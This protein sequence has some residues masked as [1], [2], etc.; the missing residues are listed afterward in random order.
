MATHETGLHPV[1]MSIQKEPQRSCPL[2]GSAER[3]L[4]C[5]DLFDY[6][7]G[8]SVERW[9]AQECIE[10][11][12]LYL[13]PRPTRETV[14]YAY[15]GYYTHAAVAAVAAVEM[16]R[17]GRAI[18]FMMA[19]KNGVLN[20]RFG[21]AL[22]PTIDIPLVTKALSLL[23]RG[24]AL[25]R[26]RYFRRLAPGAKVLDVGC[27]SGK[28]LALAKR[29]GWCA[30]GLDFDRDAIS[31]ARSAGFDAQIG[32][33]LTTSFPDEHFDAITF[34]HSF[35]HLY[36]PKLVVSRTYA[37]LQPGGFV[38]MEMPNPSATGR[39]VF[40][41]FWRGYEVPR[42]IQL[43]SHAAM[44]QV[45][46]AAGF[47]NVYFKSS[48]WATTGMYK[49]SLAN[50][51][52]ADSVTYLHRLAWVARASSLLAPRSTHEFTVLVAVK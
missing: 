2:C 19:L 30:S 32:D 3:R 10:C 49:A 29:S 35:E 45:L 11:R 28:F 7:F 14:M 24:S 22:S 52:G 38:H 17:H 23:V 47:S 36:D 39:K 50:A 1:G 18:L 20:R 34:N 41:K 12:S 31:A 6:D 9:A 48:S 40:G 42:H 13:D 16:K 27:G 51:R 33:I 43:P 5:G 8:K 44:K 37:L 21:T 4:A 25:R 15:E 46:I 26:Y